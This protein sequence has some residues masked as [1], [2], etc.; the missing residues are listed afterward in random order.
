MHENIKLM[1]SNQ[2]IFA[3]LAKKND[4]TFDKMYK[5]DRGIMHHNHV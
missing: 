3:I 4:L 1:S 5:Y 2:I